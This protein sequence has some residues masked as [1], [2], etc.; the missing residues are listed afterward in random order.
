MMTKYKTASTHLNNRIQLRRQLRKQIRKLETF[1]NSKS[2]NDEAINSKSP[3]S[4]KCS[5]S[6]ISYRKILKSS[7]GAHPLKNPFVINVAIDQIIETTKTLAAGQ[8]HKAAHLNA[9]NTTT[10]QQHQRTFVEAKA[11]Q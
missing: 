6:R 4:E 7:K 5:D 1:L 8:P 2:D 11:V 10:L 9:L 3:D